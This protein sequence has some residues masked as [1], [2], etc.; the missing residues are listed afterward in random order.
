MSPKS[1]W[2]EFIIDLGDTV[3]GIGIGIVTQTYSTGLLCFSLFILIAAFILKIPPKEK[4]EFT[5]EHYEVFTVD[6]D[7]EQFIITMM[8][9]DPKKLMQY[10]TLISGRECNKANVNQLVTQVDANLIDGKRYRVVQTVEIK[11]L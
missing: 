3:G 2:R 10:Y 1:R 8:E 4:T 6:K 5:K 11:E 7:V 9:K